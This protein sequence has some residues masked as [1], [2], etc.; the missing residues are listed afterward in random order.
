MQ[1]SNIKFHNL[2]SSE[3]Y[4]CSPFVSY[5][6]YECYIL[7]NNVS[8]LTYSNMS[9]H[10]PSLY[11]F[12]IMKWPV[13]LLAFVSTLIC[14]KNSLIEVSHCQ[15][16]QEIVGNVAT[17]YLLYWFPLSLTHPF[18]VISCENMLSHLAYNLKITNNNINSDK[19]KRSTI[20]V[21]L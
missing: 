3:K 6:I 5:W 1:I 19:S 17:I 21:I 16:L 10:M 15:Q 2:F 4:W 11:Q 9:S 20:Y 7:Y 14:V 12:L 18:S 13:T 8:F